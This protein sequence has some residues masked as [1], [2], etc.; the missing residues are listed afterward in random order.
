MLFAASSVIVLILAIGLY[1][2]HNRKL[3]PP[4]MMLAFILDILLVLVIE[5]QRQAVEQVVEGLDSTLLTFHV[6][7]S[8]T[9]VLLYIAL[10]FTGIKVLKGQNQMMSAHRMLAY[11]FIIGRLTNYITSFFVGS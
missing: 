6:I 3:H 11:A 9:V 2:R 1:F 4:I 5:L 7:V 8:V 10:L